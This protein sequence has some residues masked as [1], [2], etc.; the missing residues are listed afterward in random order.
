ML[1]SKPF[2]HI[3][4]LCESWLTKGCRQSGPEIEANAC[5][6]F[7]TNL[8]DISNAVGTTVNISSPVNHTSRV[9]TAVF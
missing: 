4:S 6:I 7:T 5:Y 8:F 1:E 3:D 9:R 2:T